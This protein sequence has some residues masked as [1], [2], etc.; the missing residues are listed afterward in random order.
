MAAKRFAGKWLFW[1]A[2]VL[3][4]IAAV[5][6]TVRPDPVWVDL[7]TVS[8]GPME[9]T[10]RE[11]GRTRVRDRY[12]VSSPVAGFLHRVLL[13]VG[14]PVIPGELLT[15]VD[16]M[17]ASTLDARSR[18]EAEA[19]VQS[20]RSALNSTRQK[21]TAA[22]AEAD[23][24]MRELAR[25]QALRGDH[26][27]SE[28]RL[29]QAKAASDRAQAI[30]R[31]ARFDEEV[32]A[33]ELAAARTRLEVSAARA[34]GNGAVER[35][36]VRSPVNGSV[37]GIIRKSEGVIHAGEA[38]LE[39]GDPGALEVVID[40]LSFDAVKL[41][42]GVTV[43]LTGWGGGT[44]DAVVRR[45]EPV[46][47]EDVSALGVEER[48]V[49]VVADITSPLEAWETLGDGYRVDAEF[50]L[51]ASADELQIPESAIFRKD[52]QSLVFRVVGE[53]GELTTVSTG[54]TNGFYTVILDGLSEGDLVVRHPGRQLE[55]GSRV[56][57][58]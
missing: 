57:V 56:R 15:E 32:M 13:E 52:G 44:L 41:S 53:R 29:Q 21:A 48:R 8:R 16:P 6:F 11:E 2:F 43:R 51:W 31:S 33:H 38:I 54:R 40:V 30:L 5:V 10:I 12:V 35:V 47:F 49:Q 22:E 24:A 3:L 37:L 34:S 45:V 26:F 39:L 55:D 20:A 28:E 18:A 42:P 36:P 58:R 9:I 1:G 7:A 14:D 25:L 4:A 23:L 27:V 19:K 17:P 50:V 46:G